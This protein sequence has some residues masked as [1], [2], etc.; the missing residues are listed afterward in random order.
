MGI[1]DLRLV[2]NALLAKCKWRWG[3][4]TEGIGIWRDILLD[5]YGSLFP[6][7]HLAGRPNGLRGASLWW[8]DVSLLGTQVDFHSGW[9]SDGVTK[10]IGN[11]TL[12]SFWFD[13]WVDGVPLRIRYQSLFQASDQ[14]LDRIVDMGSWVRLSHSDDEWCLRHEPGNNIVNLA[15]VWDSWA[16]TKVIG[17]SWQLLQDRIPTWQNL[18]R[19]RVMIG[20]SS[21][22]C[23]F[24][25]AV[26]ETVDH[27]FV[28]CDRI[29]PVWYCVSRW[30]GIE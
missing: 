1:R 2:N 3:I 18:S 6:T 5:R 12:T 17:F 30:L 23:V 4:L 10:R 20:D 8:N 13:P 15:R 14:C 19:R 9:F 7:P 28:S 27:L 24:C 26:E 16:A 21:T 29:S 11:G 25:G 22:S